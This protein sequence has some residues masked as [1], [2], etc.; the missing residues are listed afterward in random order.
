[1]LTGVTVGEMTHFHGRGSKRK[2]QGGP[3]VLV[4]FSFL[5]VFFMGYPIF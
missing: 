5:L 4:H 3:R 2:A 1:M